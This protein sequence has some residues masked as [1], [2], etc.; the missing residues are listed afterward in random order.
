M[1]KFIAVYKHVWGTRVYPFATPSTAFDGLLWNEKNKLALARL[2][3]CEYDPHN[4]SDDEK[5]TILECPDTVV[6]SENDAAQVW[7]SDDIG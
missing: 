5:F 2:L 1:H 6:I 4:N 3:G 7:A